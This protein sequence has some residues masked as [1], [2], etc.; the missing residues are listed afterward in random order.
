MSKCYASVLS[1]LDYWFFSYCGYFQ[2]TRFVNNLTELLSMRRIAVPEYGF[3][4][5]QLIPMLV[6]FFTY[7]IA[8]FAQ[9][10]EAAVSP[11]VNESEAWYSIP[12]WYV[13]NHL[14]FLLVTDLFLSSLVT[15]SIL[16]NRW[17]LFHH[18]CVELHFRSTWNLGN[19][20]MHCCCWINQRPI[21]SNTFISDLSGEWSLINHSRSD[22]QMG[23]VMEKGVWCICLPSTYMSDEFV[24][25]NF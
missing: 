5:L 20:Q 3:M 18:F 14:W 25:E 10:I 4:H 19:S 16:L 9:A 15:S 24:L 12:W 21:G 1:Q 8:T 6:G 11:V 22:N 23:R 17:V 2:L 7:K 13:K